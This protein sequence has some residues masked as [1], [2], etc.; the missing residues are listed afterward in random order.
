LFERDF[1]SS[2][3]ATDVPRLVSRYRPIGPGLTAGIDM[4]TTSRSP[5]AAPRTLVKGRRR[6]GCLLTA[7]LEHAMDAETIRHHIALCDESA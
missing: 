2:V 7:G 3:D 5:N 6:T 1:P 4:M